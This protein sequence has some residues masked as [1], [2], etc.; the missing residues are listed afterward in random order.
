MTLDNR[1]PIRVVVGED[2]PLFRA[3]VVHVLREAGLDV[4]AAAGDA[5]DLVL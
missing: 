5:R 3:G 1:F 2:Q 4:V